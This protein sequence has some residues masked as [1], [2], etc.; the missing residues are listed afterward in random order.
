[1]LCVAA[2]RV[3]SNHFCCR[4]F[5]P[6]LAL[7]QPHDLFAQC[8]QRA[9][10]VANNNNCAALAAKLLNLFAALALKLLVANGKHLV[11]QQDL[12]FYV[13]GNREA[14]AHGHARRIVLYRGVNEPLQTSKFD[15]A[16]ELAV[17]I[18]FRHAQNCGVEINVFAARQFGVE[19]STQF[20]QCGNI[21]IDRNF[22]LIG[23]I[24]AGEALQHGAFARPVGA[25]DSNS[26]T[27]VHIERDI[28]ERP[29]LFVTGAPAAQNCSL[30]VAVSFVVQTK[31]FGDRINGD[32]VLRHLYAS[33]L[34][35]W[36]RVLFAQQLQ[37]RTQ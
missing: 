18:F 37:V 9:K 10:A 5:H 14:Q 31:V 1:M 29:E 20:Q 28:V 33:L 36:R 13:G 8:L 23:P 25:N 11:N 2:A 6:K 15:D 24:N 3:C 22:A 16:V 17:D 35:Y 30:D 21:A 4:A 27:V 26:C 7:F 34:I 32:C 19:A 12:G